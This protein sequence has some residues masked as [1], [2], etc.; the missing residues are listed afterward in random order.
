MNE[1]NIPLKRQTKKTVFVGSVR[2]RKMG[3]RQRLGKCCESLS[4]REKESELQT[5]IR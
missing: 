4:Q 5:K 2:E 1:F 3:K